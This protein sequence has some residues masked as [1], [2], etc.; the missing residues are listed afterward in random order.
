MQLRTL[1]SD[2][3]QLV[4]RVRSAQNKLK[5]T[6]Q[7]DDKLRTALKSIASKLLT[8]PVR[9]GKP[10][11]Q[12]HITYL[13]SMTATVD[14]QIGHDAEERYE[15]LRKE[16]ESLKIEVDRLLGPAA[17]KQDSLAQ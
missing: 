6:Q 10:G 9:Y 12:A 11:L 15:T 4:S 2:V 8:E 5:E 16:L 14:Q 13:G 1:I 17:T 3:N 7:S